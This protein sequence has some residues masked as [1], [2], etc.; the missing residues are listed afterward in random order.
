MIRS[1]KL[2]EHSHTIRTRTTKLNIERRIRELNSE[3]SLNQHD[4]D[5][6]LILKA[7]QVL[8]TSTPDL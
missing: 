1:L 6:L 8:L 3:K 5:I 2:R 7:L 4:Q